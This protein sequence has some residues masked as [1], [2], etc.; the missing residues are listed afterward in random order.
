M[1][2]N[3]DLARPTPG[4]ENKYLITRDGEIY[5]LKRNRFLKKSLDK[6]GYEIISLQKN[7]KS[8]TKKV[9]RLVAITYIANPCNY[10]QVNHIDGNTLNNSVSNLEW[11]NNSQNMNHLYHILNYKQSEDHRHKNS[12]A[13]SGKNNAMYGV[14][15][16]GKESPCYGKSICKEYKWI[17]KDGKRT[18]VKPIDLQRYI[19][20]GWNIGFNLMG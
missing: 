13:N 8:V 12:V 2:N 10:P 19:D 1:H 15:R 4:F 6:D 16:Y 9:H 17:H 7:G 11:C 18:R 20:D 3:S 14:H 5:S